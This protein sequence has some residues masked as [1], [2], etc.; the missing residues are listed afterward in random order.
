VK[1]KSIGSLI[2]L[3]V[4][5]PAC[6][7]GGSGAKHPITPPRWSEQ[8]RSPT[9][10]DLR[11]VRFGDP[12]HGIAA[13]KFGTFVR[14]DDGGTTWRYLE[15]LPNTPTGDI[16]RLAT[17][18]TTT[19][20]VGGTPAGA[21]TYT[22]GVAWTSLDATDFS[23]ADSLL[24]VFAEP[25]VDVGLAVPATNSVAAGTL[26]LR[27]SGLLDVFQGTLQV[28][29]DSTQ[30]PPDSGGNP[31]PPT[32]WTV[33]NGLA[34]FGSTGYW[35][36]CGDNAGGQIRRTKDGGTSKFDTLKLSGACP[37][38]NRLSMLS[39]TVGFACGS[40]GTVL[41]IAADPG[42]SPPAV[43]L[44]DYWKIL[45]TPPAATNLRSIFAI[46]QNVAWMVGDGGT[47]WRVR[48]VVSGGTLTW[49]QIASP[50][51]VNLYDVWFADADHGFAVGDNGVVVRTVNGSTTSGLPTWTMVPGPASPTATFNAVDV[52]ASGVV[53]LT[54][55]SNSTLVRSTDS[56]TTWLPFTMSL[57]GGKNLTAV[58]IP[59][60]GSGTVAFVGD[61]AGDLYFNTN[62][63]GPAT[64]P[65]ATAAGT[66][67]PFG[68][69][70][71]AILFPQGDTAGVVVGASGN[72]ARITYTPAV[73]SPPTAASV[74]LTPVAMGTTATLNTLAADP[75]GTTLYV[76]GDS[77]FL[78]MS[79]DS[80]ATWSAVPAAAPLS[81]TISIRSLQAP[82]GNAF[83]LYAAA[84]DGNVW[85][86]SKGS[87]GSW[88]STTT[89]NFGTPAGIAFIDDT[90]GWTLTQDAT[91]GGVFYTNSA[92]ATWT[93]QVLHVP[94]DNTT[95]ILNAIR[96]LPSLEGFVVGANG[97]LIR[98][99]TGGK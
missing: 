5:A 3:A 97:E 62:L 70:I 10:V 93:R 67:T 64:A 13:G 48:N 14:T 80:G 46:S 50:T 77:G 7:G 4:L 65:W 27:P 35:L 30:N 78:K 34:I 68:V 63:A 32:P 20:A 99:T 11:S 18:S 41:T 6:G 74:S 54:V 19:F 90:N 60:L 36:I 31:Q 83:T 44:G 76:G 26:R 28:T 73:V 9:S 52:T 56:G 59:R 94:V 40:G 25:W 1:N 89:A 92:G 22:G 95:H 85:R 17:G 42:T 79:T 72:L 61:D 55:G 49:D 81:G 88:S 47:I 69:A 39:T 24:T 12:F 21:G 15:S 16:L 33:A 53:G 71:K 23:Q 66:G 58:A 98:T 8:Y 91:H 2:L 87:P 43:P 51:A 82:S 86:L 75:T 37:A 38:L 96:M 84:D 29:L 45:P 57:S